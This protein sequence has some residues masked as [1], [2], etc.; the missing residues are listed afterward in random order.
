MG[1]KNAL[2]EA[3]KKGRIQENYINEAV[4]RILRAKLKIGIIK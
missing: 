2:I 1:S 3:I 4:L